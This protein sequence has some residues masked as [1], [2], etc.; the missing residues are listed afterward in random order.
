MSSSSLSETRSMSSIVI[1]DGSIE[2]AHNIPKAST[3]CVRRS[4]KGCYVAHAVTLSQHTQ[5]TNVKIPVHVT[6][7]ND[8][9]RD[10]LRPSRS[11]LCSSSS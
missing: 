2:L 6:I 1:L 7:S 11:R 3:E 4:G 8:V 10:S 5:T 9:P